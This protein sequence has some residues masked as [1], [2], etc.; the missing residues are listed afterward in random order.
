[1]IKSIGLLLLALTMPAASAF[2]ADEETGPLETRSLIPVRLAEAATLAARARFPD[3]AQQRELFIRDYA[4]A[5]LD[6][7]RLGDRFQHLTKMGGEAGSLAGFEAAKAAILDPQTRIT[8]TPSEFGYGLITTEGRYRGF[9]EVSELKPET[10]D[11]FEI[12][13][14]ET[15]PPPNK[16]RVRV[17]GYV[18]PKIPGGYGHMGAHPREIIVTSYTVLSPAEPKAP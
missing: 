6:R 14:G 2:A 5:Y 13:W 1:M 12:C 11:A 18:S 9:F 7:C 4:E 17:T 15:R 16:S 3:D 10:G 8:V